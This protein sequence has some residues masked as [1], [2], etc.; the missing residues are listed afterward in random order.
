MEDFIV[1]IDVI[2]RKPH[3]KYQT[4]LVIKILDKIVLCKNIEIPFQE[5]CIIKAE[6]QPSP[7]PFIVNLTSLN[8]K[9]N[10]ELTCLF[11][12]GFHSILKIIY[13]E[14]SFLGTEAMGIAECKKGSTFNLENFIKDLEIEDKELK[15]KKLSLI[16]DKKIYSKN[17]KK[18]NKKKKKKGKEE[19]HTST[20]EKD[21]RSD[22]VD[23][24]CGNQRVEVTE[25]IN[26]NNLEDNV[27]DKELFNKYNLDNKV[28]YIF[29]ILSH[30]S[31]II[32]AQQKELLECKEK[33]KELEENRI[34]NQLFSN[35]IDKF[36]VYMMNKNHLKT[37]ENL[38]L[39]EEFLRIISFKDKNYENF[40]KR[41]SLLKDLIDQKDIDQFQ[42][43]LNTGNSRINDNLYL[44]ILNIILTYMNS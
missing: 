15:E 39:K 12:L 4:L 33:L 24:T 20:H 16:K 35:L 1:L 10:E 26:T 25:S 17:N 7:I 23:N 43:V 14:E 36:V 40:N 30:Q 29:D 8:S 32:K 41:F 6:R 44:I 34:N 18:H 28:D 19:D 21:E 2:S 31:L 3:I 13:D 22:I 27:I 9:K 38:N 42:E 37:I 5:K 11:H